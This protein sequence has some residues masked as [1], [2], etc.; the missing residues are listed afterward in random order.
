MS[1]K[2]NQK[3]VVFYYFIVVFGCFFQLE[4]VNLDLGNV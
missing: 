2:L 4:T 1:G 3:K